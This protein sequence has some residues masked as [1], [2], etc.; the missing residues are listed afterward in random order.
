MIFQLLFFLILMMGVHTIWLVSYDI[1][2]PK[3]LRRVEKAIAAVGVRLHYSVFQCEL[4]VDELHA[5]QERIA[6]II[7]AQKDGIQ[8]IPWCVADRK[9]TRYI[10]EP[11]NPTEIPNS[12]VV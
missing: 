11:L 1:A 7:D 6:S 12:W 4:Q 8:Y 2:D 5:L 3:R 9:T 10:G